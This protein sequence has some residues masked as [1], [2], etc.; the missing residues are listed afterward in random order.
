[1][2]VTASTML[3]LGTP[4]PPFALPDPAGTTVSSD[5]LAHAPALLVMFLCNHCPYV[6]HV[7][8]GLAEV[9]RDLQ[10][11]GVAVVGV[12]SNDA[13]AYADDRPERMAEVAAE[14]GYSFPFLV[15]ESQVVAAAYRAA[16]T[17]DFFLFDRD[18]RLAYRGQM[19]GS[20]PGNDVAVTGDD[21]QAAAEAVLA[22]QPV[23]EPQ[24]PSIGCDIKWRPGNRPDYA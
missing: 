11:R 22:G 3:P 20:R 21:L 24:R 12:N 9:V 17:P 23:P 5:D 18:R 16:C 4:A 8:R 13:G 1:M 10:A 6:R 2:T 15:D 14:V 7:R 19:D